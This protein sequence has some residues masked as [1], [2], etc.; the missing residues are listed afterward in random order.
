MTTMQLVPGD[1]IRVDGCV[2]RVLHVGAEGFIFKRLGIA[3]RGWRW[4]LRIF[5][6]PVQPVLGALWAPK[7]TR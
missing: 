4:V 2:G 6:R 1:L 3:E 7:S 5:R